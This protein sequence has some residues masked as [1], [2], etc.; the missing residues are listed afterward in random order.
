MS[1][2]ALAKAVATELLHLDSVGCRARRVQLLVLVA[3]QLLLQQVNAANSDVLLIVVRLS[4]VNLVDVQADVL[5][6]L[7]SKLLVA[8]GF[9]L[10]QDAL[11][12]DLLAVE[13]ALMMVLDFGHKLLLLRTWHPHG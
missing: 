1:I 2:V 10:G 4:L 6:L 8:L 11:T 7:R 13:G 3:S 12:V 9:T 5:M